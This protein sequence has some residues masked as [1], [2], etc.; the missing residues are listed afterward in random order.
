MSNRWQAS[1]TYTLS[2]FYNAENQPF[3]GLTIVPFTVQPDLGN[4]WTL[5]A[6]DQRHR[7]V[8][9]GI[10]A[11]GRGFQLSGLHFLAAGRRSGATYGGDLRNLGA[12]GTARLRPDGTIVP[13]NAFIQPPENRTD[14][15]VQQRIP[16]GSR[17][18]VDAIAEVFNVFN[19]PNWGVSTTE[20]ASNYNQRTSAQFRQAQVGFRVTF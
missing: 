18:A 12:G 9:N 6:D 4:E 13:R 14:V 5:S 10:W 19:R 3:Q 16:L 1:A 17:V 15:R 11:V 8:F 7:A 20:S 2:W